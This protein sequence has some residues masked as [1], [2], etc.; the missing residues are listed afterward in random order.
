MKV[1]KMIFWGLGMTYRKEFFHWLCQPPPAEKVSGTA[2]RE[3][4]EGRAGI[5]FRVEELLL[6]VMLQTPVLS[7]GPWNLWR[8]E[9]RFV[10]LDT[11]VTYNREQTCWETF[12]VSTHS[13]VRILLST[14]HPSP[15]FLPFINITPPPHKKPAEVSDWV[16]CRGNVLLFWPFFMEK[17]KYLVSPG[18]LFKLDRI[19]TA[20]IVD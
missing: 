11:D 6:R 9:A 5:R 16:G 18:F 13:T 2:R 12:V 19:C 10:G 20:D 8:A 3:G 7:T 4:G 17:E 14:T 15:L 1:T